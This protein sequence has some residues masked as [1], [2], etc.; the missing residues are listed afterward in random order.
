MK[1]K[2]PSLPKLPVNGERR[3]VEYYPILPTALDDGYTVWF[4]HY[5][6]IEEWVNIEYDLSE[7]Y[8]KTIKTS[9]CHPDKP[10]TGSNHNQ[11]ETCGYA[12]GHCGQC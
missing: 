10:T 9:V 7:S 5:Y 3:I 12:K 6:A 4:E 11:C 1:W 2:T 8:W